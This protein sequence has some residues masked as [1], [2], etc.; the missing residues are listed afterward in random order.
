MESAQALHGLYHGECVALGM[1][2]MCSDAVRARLLP[3]LG[4]L[5]LPVSLPTDPETVLGFIS[6][7]KKCQGSRISVIYVPE[8]GEFEIQTV[9]VTDFCDRVRPI[10]AS[11]I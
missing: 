7:D 5:G 10:L 3:I 4:R 8:I 2:P 6:H 9:D 11:M 1:I